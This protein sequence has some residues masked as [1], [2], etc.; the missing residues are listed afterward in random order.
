MTM[1]E[2][3][4]ERPG[5]LR[6]T[7]T[8]GKISKRPKKLSRLFSFPR[9]KSAL[10]LGNDDRE[11]RLPSNR[12][13]GGRGY[14]KSCSESVSSVSQGPPSSPQSSPP[15]RRYFKYTLFSDED[16][17]PSPPRASCP[18]SSRSKAA[19]STRVTHAM[20]PSPHG[21]I[22]TTAAHC[23]SGSLLHSD[24]SFSHSS[25]LTDS[26]HY[27]PHS[28]SLQHSDPSSSRGSTS[29][30][31]SHCHPNSGSLPYANPSSSHDSTLTNSVHY[32][33]HSGSLQHSDPSSSRGSTSITASHC[34]PNSGSLPYADPSSS[35]DSTLTDSAHYHPHSGSLQHSDPSS[36]RGSTSITASHCHPNSGSLPYA[37]PSSSHGS[38]LMDS[39]HYHPHSGSLQHS[40]PSSSRGSTSI[41]ASHCHPNSGSLPYAD[42]SSSHGSTLTDS[43]HYHPHS[44]TLRHTDLS[45]PPRVVALDCE[46]VGVHSMR[47][48]K[49]KE[50]NALA[51]CSIVDYNGDVL[52]NEYIRPEGRIKSFR[53]RWSG[54]RACHMKLAIPYR[55]AVRRIKA[56]LEGCTVVGHALANDFAVI[57]KMRHP[58]KMTRDTASFVHLRRA[59]GLKP[60]S[61]PNLKRLCA[62]L[63]GRKIQVG[64]HCSL[65]DARAALDIYRRFEDVWEQEVRGKG[66]WLSDPYWPHDIIN[67]NSNSVEGTRHQAPV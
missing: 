67:G 65:E 25:T 66:E 34:H 49:A 39:A 6:G 24:P 62:A 54:I 43:A 56:L 11:L 12:S 51:R 15:P 38:T 45:R 16:H 14:P 47:N 26:S 33:P 63:L 5:I 36:S 44:G 41:T 50:D 64:P 52:F 57:D 22:L 17:T 3:D 48:T 42:P 18:S 1:E 8:N 27:H 37:D 21:S 4:G 10:E 58:R 7:R 29:I 32:H 40:D 20:I 23:H 2:K 55:E 19:E 28:G 53:T 13:E 59:A 35:H 30:T 46:M 60:R 9:R 61:P 31:A